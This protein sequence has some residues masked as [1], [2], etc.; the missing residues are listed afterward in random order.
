MDQI[1]KQKT[2]IF[3]GLIT[4]VVLWR[5]YYFYHTLPNLDAYHMLKSSLMAPFGAAPWYSGWPGSVQHLLSA[6][7]AY[8]VITAKLIGG[9][10]GGQGL[11]T[12]LLEQHVAHAYQDLYT[13]YRYTG[14]YFIGLSIVEGMLIYKITRHFNWSTP[15]SLLIAVLILLLPMHM[16]VSTLNIRPDAFLKIAFLGSFYYYLKYADQPSLQR[17]LWISCFTAL[18]FASKYSFALWFICLVVFICSRRKPKAIKHGVLV[19]LLTLLITLLLNPYLV[20]NPAAMSK[21]FA[22]LAS[23]LTGHIPQA[24]DFKGNSWFMILRL[25]PLVVVAIIGA[26]LWM[27]K[28]YRQNSSLYGKNQAVIW[29]LAI[30]SALFLIVI[31]CSGYFEAHY[32]LPITVFMPILL[33]LL[34]APLTKKS[35]VRHVFIGCFS[36]MLIGKIAYNQHMFFPDKQSVGKQATAWIMQNVPNNS[37]VV[38]DFGEIFLPQNQASYHFIKQE[39]EQR[40]YKDRYTYYNNE[41]LQS[42]FNKEEQVELFESRLALRHPASKRP[43][44]HT[45]FVMRTIKNQ[46]ML[47]MLNPDLIILPYSID[48]QTTEEPT[49]LFMHQLISES[50]SLLKTFEDHRHK[51]I[52]L[53]KINK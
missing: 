1:A 41:I 49:R 29:W 7:S 23:I 35:L 33:G 27:A 31:R 51:K 48:N 32:F 36:I 17:C 8:V 30:Y 24:I 50:G 9:L 21:G 44:F 19:L 37:V 3:T 40:I 47:E 12:H 28:S 39:V 6:I 4:T 10:M 2:L 53:Y 13:Y 46:A 42:L 43:R 26:L 52:L 20:A 45:Y 11:S 25:F 16:G 34:Y 5:Y 18:G 38:Y 22:T 15:Y 14:P